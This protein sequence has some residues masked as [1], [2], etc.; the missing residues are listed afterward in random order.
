VTKGLELILRLPKLRLIMLVRDPRAT[1]Q[2]RSRRVWCRRKTGNRNRD[3]WDPVR[4]CDGMTADYDA[5]EELR[6]VSL[7]VIGLLKAGSFKMPFQASIS[8]PFRGR[9]V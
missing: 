6:F 3:C 5:A 8:G 9:Q 4:L 7:L 2:S 1:I